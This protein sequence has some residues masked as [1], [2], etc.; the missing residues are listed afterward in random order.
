MLTCLTYQQSAA[1]TLRHFGHS[2]KDT[3]VTNIINDSSVSSKCPNKPWQLASLHNIRNVK[4][5]C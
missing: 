4:P 1:C 2:S 5:N 3:G